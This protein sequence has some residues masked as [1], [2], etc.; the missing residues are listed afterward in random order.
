MPAVN[1]T[2]LKNRMGNS[3]NSATIQL[4]LAMIQKAMDT[5]GKNLVLSFLVSK[6]NTMATVTVGTAIMMP[7]VRQVMSQHKSLMSH[8]GMCAISKRNRRLL[9]CM[10]ILFDG[11]IMDSIC[12][13]ETQFNI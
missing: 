7:V 4:A 3:K 2:M 10:V 12:L 9:G 13:I 11:N 6:A 5:L 8:S 1:G